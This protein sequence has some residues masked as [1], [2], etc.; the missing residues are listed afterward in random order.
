MNVEKLYQEM[1]EEEPNEVFL[2]TRPQIPT[3]SI[4]IQGRDIFKEYIKAKRRKSRTQMLLYMYYLGEIFETDEENPNRDFKKHKYASLY[5]FK[6]AIKTYQLFRYVGPEQ[7]YRTKHITITHISN[8]H[9][10]KIKD[11]A[12]YIAL[13]LYTQVFQPKV[14]NQ[15]EES[16]T[17]EEN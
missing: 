12:E 15:G 16:V 1:L 9:V 14:E 13:Q 7:I 5:Y 8:L 3:D 10:D 6:I 2:E 4:E 17:L 11:A